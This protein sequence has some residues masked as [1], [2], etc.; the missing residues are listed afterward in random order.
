M[1]DVTPAGVIKQHNG[2]DTYRTRSTRAQPDQDSRNAE[3]PTGMYAFER[4]SLAMWAWIIVG[5]DPRRNVA[6]GAVVV[7]E[8]GVH[9]F[10]IGIDWAFMPLVPYTVLRAPFSGG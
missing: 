6:I 8:A 4:P 5:L 10:E 1:E 3:Q 7:F 9:R 2:V